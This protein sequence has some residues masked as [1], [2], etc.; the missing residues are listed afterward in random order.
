MHTLPMVSSENSICI[1]IC[2]SAHHGPFLDLNTDTIASFIFRY[3]QP[4]S[5]SE[6]LFLYGLTAGARRYR[7]FGT[8]GQ[9]VE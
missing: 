9:A 5:W 3:Y 7:K 4:C 8:F 1:K 6:A 2:T